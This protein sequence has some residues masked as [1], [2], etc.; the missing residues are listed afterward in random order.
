MTDGGR[1]DNFP[2]ATVVFDYVLV[3]RNQRTLHREV[4]AA[5]DDTERGTFT[6]E[7]EVRCETVKR[8]GGRTKRRTCS[9]LGSPSFYERVAVPEA[10]ST[11]A[12]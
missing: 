8:N 2:V 7:A 12:A 1:H 4:K 11:C 9:V 5:F 3:R 6:P 10:C